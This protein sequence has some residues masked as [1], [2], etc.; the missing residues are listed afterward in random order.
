MMIMDG[1]EKITP[2][3]ARVLLV[4]LITTSQLVS[5]GG[6]ACEPP[7][8]IHFLGQTMG[9]SGPRNSFISRRGWSPSLLTLDM[10][11]IRSGL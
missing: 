7:L 4:A 9:P 11:I 3:G 10:V 5:R 2:D 8:D 6:R 1:W